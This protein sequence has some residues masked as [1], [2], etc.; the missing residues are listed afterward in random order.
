[1][2][3]KKSNVRYCK[4]CGFK[5]RGSEHEDGDHHKR[6]KEGRHKVISRK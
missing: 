5:I 1:M 4:E 2:K 3:Q 6:G